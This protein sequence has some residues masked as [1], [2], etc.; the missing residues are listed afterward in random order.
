MIQSTKNTILVLPPAPQ[1]LTPTKR[2]HLAYSSKLSIIFLLQNLEDFP[3]GLGGVLD[4]ARLSTGSQRTK[5]PE[6]ALII[7]QREVETT[8]TKQSCGGRWAQR[9]AVLG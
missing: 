7:V 9:R 5:Q 4:L 2:R 8:V 1:Q 3:M 6:K